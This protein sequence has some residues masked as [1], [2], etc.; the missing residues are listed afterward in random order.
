MRRIG[1]LMVGLLVLGA[2]PAQAE[3]DVVKQIPCS[4]GARVRLEVTDIGDR[5]KVRIEVHRS[6]VGHDWRIHLR[7]KSHSFA[8]STAYGHVFF[9]RTR[10][11]SD[12]G[13]LV[14]QLARPDWDRA[15]QVH[16]DGVDGRAV[17][18]QTGEVCEAS[19]WYR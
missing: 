1:I 15:G 6:P 16:P 19:A 8:N 12:G 10:V 9:R 18:R 5:I 3:P 4:D 13:D 14:A 11:A 7:Y 17:D 2:V